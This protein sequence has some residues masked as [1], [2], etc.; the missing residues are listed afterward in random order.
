MATLFFAYQTQAIR[1]ANSRNFVVGPKDPRG[2]GATTV[3]PLR[4]GRGWK[5]R[6][7]GTRL[8]LEEL[9]LHRLI[10]EAEESR[11]TSPVER[12][13]LAQKAARR[14][15]GSTLLDMSGPAIRA[16]DGDFIFGSPPHG[17]HSRSTYR[18]PVQAQPSTSPRTDIG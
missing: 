1:Y 13:Y 7:R 16:E 15:P 17:N 9:E 2:A 4:V 8:P 12:D 18:K 11:G 14:V 5:F 6:R 10:S 3:S